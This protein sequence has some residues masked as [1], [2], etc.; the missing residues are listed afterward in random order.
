VRGKEGFSLG[1]CRARASQASRIQ[2]ACASQLLGPSPAVPQIRFANGRAQRGPTGSTQIL[3]QRQN[4][5]RID[6]EIS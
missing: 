5:I 2:V 4:N 1:T 6:L 3:A